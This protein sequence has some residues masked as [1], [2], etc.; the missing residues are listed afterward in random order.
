MAK[1]VRK[2][3]ADM[4]AILRKVMDLDKAEPFD[5]AFGL[6]LWVLASD[7]RIQRMAMF[8]PV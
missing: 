6:W 5:P 4:H 7:E 1:D 8:F 3:W 2:D